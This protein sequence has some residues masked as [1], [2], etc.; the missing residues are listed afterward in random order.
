MKILI[1]GASGFVGWNAVRHF[2]DRGFFVQPTFRSLPHYLHYHSEERVCTPVQTDITSRR[3]VDEVVSRFRPDFIVH[4]A[5]L[6][7]PQLS[8]SSQTV[9]D[10]NVAGTANLA[11]AASDSGARLIFLSTDI[12]YPALAGLVN[13]DSPTAPSGAGYY[14]ASKL[15][16]EKEVETHASSWTIIRPTLMFGIGTPRS[17]CFTQFLE[18]HW[19]AG[20][21][22]PVFCDQIRSFLYVGDLLAALETVIA[23]PEAINRLFVCGGGESITRAEFALCYAE[24]RGVDPAL[25]NVMRSTELEGYVGGPSDIRLDTAKLQE[26]GWRAR[27]LTECFAEMERERGKFQEEGA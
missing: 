12:V 19:A 14:S 25:C 2:A 3:A 26:L 20:R 4:C 15:L 8:G 6:A 10:V 16:A 13:E 22:A 23:R 21:A 17:N 11:Q 18:R 5:A 9:H 27:P 24:A 1:T 7:H